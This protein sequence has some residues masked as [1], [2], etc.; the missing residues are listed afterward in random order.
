MGSRPAHTRYRAWSVFW[1]DPSLLPSQLAVST[2]AV[3]ALIAFR[4]SIGDLLPPV[5]YMTRGDVFVLGCTLL[6]FSAFGEAVVTGRLA[7]GGRENLARKLDR[8][9]RW[10]YLTAFGLLYDGVVMKPQG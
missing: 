6:V 4:L 10:L 9:S 1:I 2:A 8:W 5:P 3:F 7:K